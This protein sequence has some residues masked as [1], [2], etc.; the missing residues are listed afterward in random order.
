MAR[1]G[2]KRH[3]K[4]KKKVLPFVVS[5]TVLYWSHSPKGTILGKMY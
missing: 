3:R 5:V 1:V 2:P 4:K